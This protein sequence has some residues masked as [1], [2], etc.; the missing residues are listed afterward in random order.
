MPRVPTTVDAFSAIA[1]PRRRELLGVLAAGEGTHDVSRLVELLGWPQPQVSKHL[2]VL[3]KAGLVNVAQDGRRRLYS[4]HGEALRPVYEWVRSYERFWE[5]QLR[6][7]RDR[8]EQASQRTLPRMLGAP[9][10][11]TNSP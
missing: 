6:R 11:R 8:A 4:L 3:R 2:G 1:E 10:R 7:I 9:N 5:H